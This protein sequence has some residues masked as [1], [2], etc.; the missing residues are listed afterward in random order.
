MI[1]LTIGQAVFLAL[2]FSYVSYVVDTA[3]IEGLTPHDD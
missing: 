3:P 1:E 2:L